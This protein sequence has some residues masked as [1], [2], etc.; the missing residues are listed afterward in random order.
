MCGGRG[1]R[2]L[3]LI[4]GFLAAIALQPCVHAQS[5]QRL[6][7]EGGLVVSS[8]GALYLGTA[9][10]HIFVRPAIEKPWELRGR[11][12]SRT[13]AVVT[14]LLVDPTDGDRLC[15]SVWYQQANA[16]G[17]IFCSADGAKSWQLAGLNGEAVRALERAPSD[18]SMLVAGTISGVFR[19]ADS[20]KTWQR[21]SPLGDEELRNL[22][23]VAID[24]RDANT[25]YAGTYHLPWKTTDGGKTWKPVVAGL[26]DDSDIMSLRIDAKPGP[27]CRAFLTPRGARK[28]LCRIRRIPRR[29]TPRPRKDCG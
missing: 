28:Q 5:W 12:G 4:V 20:G 17:G 14:R 9:D 3:K 7:P 22:D 16:G 15:A 27:S 29:F 2:R 13:D 11:V 19:S 10:G 24:P 23:S 21:I 8:S 6:G 26:I 1:L 18:A 25:I